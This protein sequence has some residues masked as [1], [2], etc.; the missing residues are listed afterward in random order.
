MRGPFLVEAMLQGLIAAALASLLLWG[1]FALL[2][3]PGTLPWG[4]SLSQVLAF[5][6]LLAPLLAGLAL[7]C[8][9][10]GGF[11]GVGRS[12]HPREVL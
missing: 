12:L 7:L 1:L 4:L 5:P 11:L 9:L 3:A 6:P 2:A 8:G 10:L